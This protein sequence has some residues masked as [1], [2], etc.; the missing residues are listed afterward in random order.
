MKITHIWFYTSLSLEDLNDAL[1]AE[2]D[3]A[4]GENYWEW[5]VST[6]NGMELDITRTHTKPPAET[7]TI[8]FLLSNPS[9]F[10]E[11]Q[12]TLIIDKLKQS[13]IMPISLGQR[14]YIS[15]NDFEFVEMR[16]VSG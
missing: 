4:D 9:E 7:P 11:E 12:L 13:G 8:I 5:S 10:T 2:L 16:V 14:N 15:G 6:L 1:G 3:Y